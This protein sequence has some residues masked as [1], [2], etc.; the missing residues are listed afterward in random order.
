[1]T[2]DGSRNGASIAENNQ[3]LTSLAIKMNP[4]GQSMMYY[5]AKIPGFADFYYF[6]LLKETVKSS[7]CKPNTYLNLT[8]FFTQII[9][10]RIAPT[11][12]H[13]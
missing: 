8:V 7:A 11:C 5:Y 9:R 2:V 12:L 6:R 10:Q 1:V 3:T 13:K 4:A